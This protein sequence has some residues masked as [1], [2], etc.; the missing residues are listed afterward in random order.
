MLNRFRIPNEELKPSIVNNFSVGSS[1]FRIP[2]EELKL[3]SNIFNLPD[4]KLF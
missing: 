4:F 2:N 1:C 3:L